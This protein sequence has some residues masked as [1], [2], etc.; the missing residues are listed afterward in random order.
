MGNLHFLIL[1][2]FLKG[3]KLLLIIFIFTGIVIENAVYSLIEEQNTSILKDFSKNNVRKYLLLQ[4]VSLLNNIFLNLIPEL[5]KYNLNLE[6]IDILLNSFLLADINKNMKQ[7][8]GFKIKH[9][10][11]V[12]T[13]YFAFYKMPRCISRIATCIFTIFFIKLKPKGIFLYIMLFF[14]GV[15]FVLLVTSII[16]RNRIRL[17]I[18]NAISN[19][20]KYIE[21]AFK[22][23]TVV[24]AFNMEDQVHNMYYTRL[25][26]Q[27]A[28]EL[29][30][31]L[32]SEVCR[33]IMRYP[34]LI[35]HAF[36]FYNAYYENIW[37]KDVNLRMA[38]SVINTLK[39]K[40][41]ELRN[42]FSL[43]FEFLSETYFEDDLFGNAIK[44]KKND[45][46]KLVNHNDARFLPGKHAIFLFEKNDTRFLSGDIIGENVRIQKDQ[47]YLFND[48][49]PL[50]SDQES[51]ELH[52]LRENIIKTQFETNNTL[53]EVNNSKKK[54]DTQFKSIKNFKILSKKIN[55]ISKKNTI[56]YKI[57][58]NI[59]LKAVDYK[60]KIKINRLE[61]KTIDTDVIYNNIS[62]MGDRADVFNKS[63]LFNL[64]YGTGLSESEIIK[65]IK[66]LGFYDF[67]CKLPE[68]FKTKIKELDSGISS[69]Q[70]QI[71]RFCR[72]LLK[73]CEIYILDN[74]FDFLD[75]EMKWRVLQ[76]I[77]TMRNKTFII[78]S[79]EPELLEKAENIIYL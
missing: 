2:S 49:I 27:I 23:L 69:G 40:V 54:H 17:K 8:T 44:T 75:N 14:T 77:Y 70:K 56:N 73:E 33:F 19:K 9:K 3:K 55:L 71:I 48:S 4:A 5:F 30:F 39:I 53:F 34:F 7:V 79:D 35:L 78:F 29:Y 43:F 61:F 10:A 59:L 50:P 76:T 41:F 25:A 36:L 57:L 16:V 68:D 28:L 31:Q 58:A 42:D 15:L 22:N 72:C 24:K 26:K 47:T 46:V 18:N 74:P 20:M 1:K 45:L 65:K 64:K 38:I 37:I 6:I 63:V 51:N 13:Y 60:G 32:I 66:Y 52:E 12:N 67:F 21:N 11:L 62:W